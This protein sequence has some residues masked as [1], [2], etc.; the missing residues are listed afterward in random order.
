MREG[1]FSGE[2]EMRRKKSAR[3]QP[4]L[5]PMTCHRTW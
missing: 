3:A 2:E 4:R 1:R 5:S